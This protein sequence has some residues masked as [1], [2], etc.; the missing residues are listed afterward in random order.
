M[1]TIQE[2]QKRHKRE[3]FEALKR[4]S[5]LAYCQTVELPFYPELIVFNPLYGTQGTVLFNIRD[6]YSTLGSKDPEQ[7][8]LTMANELPGVPLR[9]AKSD[10]YT[11]VCVTEWL[12]ALSDEEKAKHRI[13][14]DLPMAPVHIAVNK[15]EC[16]FRWVSLFDGKPYS[17]RVETTHNVMQKYASMLYSRKIN[18]GLVYYADQ[19][20]ALA[21]SMRG[22]DYGS[23][24]LHGTA[25]AEQVRIYDGDGRG[26]WRVRWHCEG[27]GLPTV[28]ETLESVLGLGGSDA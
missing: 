28:A 20:L 14:S 3:H 17:V 12:E 11:I 16:S 18:G 27:Q 24:Y 10:G 7:D 21:E 2:M 6:Q 5:I 23:C 22:F 1:E 4:Q 15:H 13:V 19:R 26:N 25:K 9:A 8:L